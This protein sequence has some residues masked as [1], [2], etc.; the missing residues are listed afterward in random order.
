MKALFLGKFQPPHLGHIRTIFQLARSFEEVIVGVTQGEIKA[1]DYKE[2]VKILREVTE[3]LK[4]VSTVLL[5]GT[6]E[7]GTAKLDNLRFDVVV[8][9]NHKVLNL[10]AEQGYP[11]RFQPRSQGDFYSGTALRSLVEKKRS[12]YIENRSI[13]YDFKIIPISLL[14]PLEKVFPLHFANIETLIINDGVML[15]PLIVDA[16]H[17]IVLDGS[18]RYAFLL[19]H[20]YKLAPVIHVDYSE[21]AIFVGNHLRHRFLKDQDFTLTK[22]EIVSRSL[23]ENLFPPRTTRHFFPFRKIDHPVALADLDK[24]ETRNIEHLLERCSPQDEIKADEGYISEI[25][26][27]IKMLSDYIKEQN[28]VRDYLRYQVNEMKKYK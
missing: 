25:D 12:I 16:Q 10:L 18:H 24:A 4:N 26:E 19:K 14:K 11:V 13:G 9:G 3:P 7:D 21:D 27:E 5:A 15:R 1:I 17:N 22:V 8:S 23:N 28:G 6:I 2:S 20:G